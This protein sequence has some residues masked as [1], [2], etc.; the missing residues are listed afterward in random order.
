MLLEINITYIYWWL[1]V[2]SKYRLVLNNNPWERIRQTP[3]LISII[4]PHSMTTP[5]S[6]YERNICRCVLRNEPNCNQPHHQLI[7]VRYTPYSKELHT[8][9]SPVINITH[10]NTCD[11]SITLNYSATPCHVSITKNLM[12]ISS[13][14]LHL[15]FNLWQYIPQTLW[16]KRRYNI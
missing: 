7:I 11:K 2:A 13:F 5:R 16:Y 8:T 4:I 12:K 1:A 6:E 3:P 14:I 10:T 9:S 15:H